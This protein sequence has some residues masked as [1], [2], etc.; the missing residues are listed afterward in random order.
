VAGD[1][2]LLAARM[3]A[4][5]SGLKGA[6]VR[7]APGPRR[8]EWLDEL[9]AAL[10]EG[11]LVRRMPCGIED[12]RLLGGL[13]LA[14]T[15]AAGQ[16]VAARGLLAEMAGGV[17]V[18]P[19]AERLRPET[20][21]RLAQALDDDA[22]ALRLV[23]L[24]EGLD[25]E[26]VPPALA[27]RLALH[28]EL[29]AAAMPPSMTEAAPAP[30]HVEALCAV[31][32]ALG[33][34]SVRAPLLA[35]RAARAAAR[36]DGREEVEASDVALAVQLVLAPR[37][38]RLPAADAEPDS[39]PPPEPGDAADEAPSR[40]QLDALTELAIE[41]ARAVLPPDLLALQ[42]GRARGR[43]RGGRGAGQLRAGSSGGRRSGVR[44]GVP[45]H[46]AR[47]DLVETLKAAA[48]WQPLRRR[49][50]PGRSG[51]QVRRD[52]FRVR[53]RV[54]RAQATSIFVV[55][56]SGSAALARLGE[57]KGAVEL[58]LAQSYVRRD[59][60]ALIAF[61]G[62]SAE[63]LLPPTRSLA[64][65]RRAL[66]DLPGGGG[67]PLAA[68][69]EAATGLAQAVAA[70]GRTVTTLF[71]TDGR[72]NVARDPELAPM[73]D[74]EAAARRLRGLNLRTLF[75]DTSP[76]PRAEGATLAAAMG[77]TLVPLPRADA[78]A[79]AAAVRAT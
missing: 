40:D 45:R 38:T 18:V 21:A 70:K 69:I 73:A 19:S 22:A 71:L 2:A 28:L 37:A 36:L 52:D 53:V 49:E 41:A 63:L 25:E 54:K 17:I 64:R 27:E 44:A 32:V 26:S 76:R 39:A 5:D 16:P 35:V 46:G 79:L 50:A 9:K 77:A 62:A 24:D 55:D 10:P 20:A 34:G 7:A 68:A 47:L 59:E 29:D 33:I 60:V 57:A 72:A 48:P 11:L 14:A 31:S 61:R 78:A 43:D 8:D 13:D 67:T 58:L 74:A 65:A 4:L 6:V 23:L 42:A 75:I 3:L 12:E 66:A 1:A 51:A 56:A 15:L 30:D